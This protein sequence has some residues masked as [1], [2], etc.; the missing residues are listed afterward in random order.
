MTRSNGFEHRQLTIKW[1]TTNGVDA[2]ANGTHAHNYSAGIAC[3]RLADLRR[4]AILVFSS[5]FSSIVVWMCAKILRWPIPIIVALTFFH[6][7]NTNSTNKALHFVAVSNVWW[8]TKTNIS[9][10]QMKFWN[11]H[12]VAT[13]RTVNSYFALLSLGSLN[14]ANRKFDL[15]III[16]NNYRYFMTF[17]A[18]VAFIWMFL[19]LNFTKNKS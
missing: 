2:A 9:R 8:K 4:I 13:S 12:S 19:K 15:V 1:E 10:K 11:L 18:I 17:M 16:P 5:F 3:T 14:T 7:K 6:V